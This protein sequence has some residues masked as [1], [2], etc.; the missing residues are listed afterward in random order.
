MPKGRSASPKVARKFGAA[1]HDQLAA[2]A[3]GLHRIEF[4]EP[5]PVV[6]GSG[7]LRLTGELD[8]DPGA[9]VGRAPDPHQLLTLKRHVVGE[10]PRQARLGKSRRTQERQYHETADALPQ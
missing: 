6:A 3:A 2:F 7:L 9:R 5:F 1:L 10:D 4:G 8:R